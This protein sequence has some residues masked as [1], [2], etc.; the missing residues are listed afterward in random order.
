MDE[1]ECADGHGPPKEHENLEEPSV[2]ELKARH[3]SHEVHAKQ[4]IY[5]HL[6]GERYELQRLEGLVRERVPADLG[7]P[8][9]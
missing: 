2:G 1:D 4:G 3:V 6:D 9:G 8:G 5:D 7:P